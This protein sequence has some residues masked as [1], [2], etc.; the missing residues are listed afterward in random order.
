[1]ARAAVAA[2]R[3]AVGDRVAVADR[4]A[5]PVAA[6]ASERPADSAAWPKVA[7]TH[8]ILNLLGGQ[9]TTNAR[10]ITALSGIVPSRS[11]GSHVAAD[12]WQSW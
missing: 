8:S 10:P 12:S 9:I 2:G 5:G 7:G 4:A 1:V 3:A 6:A 11:Q